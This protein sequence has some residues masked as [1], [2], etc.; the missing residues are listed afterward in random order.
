MAIRMAFMALILCTVAVHAD[1]SSRLGHSHTSSLRF[2]PR[3]TPQIRFLAELNP[4]STEESEAG[5]AHEGNSELN[6]EVAKP[7]HLAPP[8]IEAKAEEEQGEERNDKECGKGRSPCEGTSFCTF[9]EATGGICRSCDEVSACTKAK[10]QKGQLACSMKCKGK[11]LP[12]AAAS[13]MRCGMHEKP[14]VEGHFCTFSS[15]NEETGECEPCS[16]QD[17]GPRACSEVHSGKGRKACVAKCASKQV[18]ATHAKVVCGHGHQ[19]CITGN[20]CTFSNADG[21]G[22]CTPCEACA[23]KSLTAK[24]TKACEAMC[25]GQAPKLAALGGGYEEP[26][27]AAPAAYQPPAYQAPAA[28][29]EQPA[30]AEPAYEPAYQQPQY[31]A[32]AHTTDQ[33][34]GCI[35]N[36]QWIRGLLGLLV[37]CSAVNFIKGPNMYDALLILFWLFFIDHLMCRKTETESSF[38]Y[39]SAS[40]GG[41]TSY[42]GKEY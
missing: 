15:G 23:G 14:C 24:G 17:E 11:E 6:H 4:T 32:Q 1:S 22:F 18:F 8:K 30:Y 28:Y 35:D 36:Y 7:I 33:V 34:E 31:I 2:S 38:S 19:R 29:A 20:F 27:Y 26:G 21:S 42:G 9:D 13:Q 3:H 41:E 5:S 10:T 40:Y 25:P 16:T 12:G 37:I 39:K